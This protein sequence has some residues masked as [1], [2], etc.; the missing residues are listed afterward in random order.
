MSSQPMKF[1]EFKAALTAKFGED[2]VRFAETGKH[3]WTSLDQM[4]D[5]LTHGNPGPHWCDA[6]PVPRTQRLLGKY[7]FV[8]GVGEFFVEV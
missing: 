1:E 3:G 6:S 7:D 2:K 4:P 8:R 5:R